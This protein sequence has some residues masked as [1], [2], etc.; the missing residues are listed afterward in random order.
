LDIASRRKTPLIASPDYS[1]FEPCFSPNGLWVSFNATTLSSSRIY[2]AAFRGPEPI[3]QNEWL[4][5]TSGDPWDDNPRWSPNGNL[6]YFT[7]EI[8]GFRCIS[9]Q[10]MDPGTKRPQ[11]PPIPIYHSHHAR[12]SLLNVGLAALKISVARDR[13]VFT[14]G[15]RSG[16][17]WM[18]KLEGK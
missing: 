12:R 18:A 5:V 3:P 10:R 6:M 13:I 11:G 17:I 8:D 16:N 7:S 15:E 1:L 4:A 2:V 14:M 9:A